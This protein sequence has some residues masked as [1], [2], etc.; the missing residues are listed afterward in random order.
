MCAAAC[1]LLWLWVGH[2]LLRRRIGWILRAKGV[3]AECGYGL[4]GLA[5]TADSLVVCP[6]CGLEAEV[7]RS[8]GELTVGAGGQVVYRLPGR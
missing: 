5:V 1:L 4:V 3:C 6:E 2:L 7:D 8:F